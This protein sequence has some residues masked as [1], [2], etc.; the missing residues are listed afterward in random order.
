MSVHGRITP[1]RRQYLELKRQHQDAILLFRLGDFYEAFDDDALVL[2]RELDLALTSREMGKGIKVPMAGI[3]YHVVDSYIAK[4]VRKGYKV[5]VCD[6]VGSSGKNSLMD[7]RVVKVVTAGTAVE[8]SLLDEREANYLAAAWVGDND[9]ALAY[10]DASSGVFRC[11]ADVGGAGRLV[12]EISRL[13]PKELL[14]PADSLENL[15]A[16]TEQL[17]DAS[18]HVT[19]FAPRYWQL[20]GAAERLKTMLNVTTLEGFGLT[21]DSPAVSA[22]GAC[23]AY[24]ELNRPSALASLDHL[25][26][27]PANHYVRLDGRVLQ[28]LEVLP[29]A[30]RGRPS[31]LGVLDKTRTAMGARLLRAWLAQPLLDI[32]EINRRLDR[33]QFFVDRPRLRSMVADMLQRIPDI[34]RILAR[35]L[36]R[37]AGP[38]DLM[39]LARGLRE[40]EVMA[41]WLQ[42][43]GMSEA[44]DL[45]PL[46]VLAAELEAAIDLTREDPTF[47]IRKGYSPQLDQLLDLALG[48]RQWIAAL[49]ERER[50]QTGIKSLKVGYNRVFGYYLEVTR[51]YL[52]LVPERYQRRQTLSGAERF[53]TPELKE[54]E[55][56]IL[57]A[58]ERAEELQVEILDDLRS[59]VALE[60]HRLRLTSS[61]LAMIDVAVALSE[62]SA[63]RNYT[64]P[65]VSQATAI[66]VRAGRHPIVE[67]FATERQFIPNDV[68]LDANG[69]QILLITG[70]NMAG[71]STYLR[72]VGL[73]VLM[74]QVGCFVPADEAEIGLVDRIFTRIGAEDNLAAGQ[75]TFLVEMIETTRALT[76]A[77]NRSLLLLDEVGRGTSTYDGLAIAQAV[78]EYLHNHPEARPRTVFATHYH[79]LTALAQRLPRIRNLRTEVYEEEGRVIFLYKVSPGSA[80][81]SYGIHVARMAGMPL[82]VVRR[83]EEILN[84]LERKR[85][86]RTEE[87]Q[88]IQLSF[89]SATEPLLEELAKIDIMG[90]TPIE[91]LNELYE[92]VCKAKET[93]GYR[94]PPSKQVTRP[95]RPS[96]TP[97]AGT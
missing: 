89:L 75:S 72:M 77:T 90:M 29:M 18:I 31:L 85:F 11:T 56:K 13:W 33:I 27:V 23:L 84:G 14:V 73:T 42:A 24:L 88:Y 62:V 60:A 5:A 41:P 32:A 81:K 51:P 58:H 44:S 68:E 78:I 45:H 17:K 12:E 4:L 40:I 48:G 96:K 26:F 95:P 8:P 64:R 19:L 70:P 30:D 35:C 59:K 38:R 63:A 94:A 80:D 50:E 83:A 20:P 46:P 6:Q 93:L 87:G 37:T 28:H 16:W 71:K 76:G 74:A 34:E 52:H 69:A 10:L 39:A 55:S 92:L 57:T 61:T 79:E 15:P 22:A 54:M 82:A 3:P 65:K 86:Q 49:E 66:R 7:R 97:R 2:S 43:E 1:I 67:A 91:A 47:Y 21:D 25:R 53:V 36:Q 9:W